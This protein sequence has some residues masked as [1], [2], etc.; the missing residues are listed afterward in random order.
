MKISSEMQ[1]TKTETNFQRVQTANPQAFEQML[2]SEGKVIK[3]QE[4]Q[5][6]LNKITEQGDKLAR[7]RS[8]Q[9]LAKFKRLI[10][11]FLKRTVSD[12]YKMETSHSFGFSGQSRQLKLVKEVDEKLIELTEQVM[13]QEEKS[14][15]IL[16][17]VG[18]LKGLLINI[19][20]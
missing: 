14:V 11:D 17:L 2:K 8:F 20:Q 18:E 4:L 12:G 15:K 6:L 1:S 5:Q 10:Q 19:Y 16:E 13:N 9:D 3:Q 7:F